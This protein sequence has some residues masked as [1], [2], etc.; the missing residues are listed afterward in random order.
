MYE[1]FKQGES[2]SLK[3]HWKTEKIPINYLLWSPFFDV[4]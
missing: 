3:V 2:F 4:E 1:Q